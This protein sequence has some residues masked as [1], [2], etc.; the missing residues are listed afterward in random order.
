M[1]EA[2]LSEYGRRKLAGALNRVRPADRPV[3]HA[4]DR[5]VGKLSEVWNWCGK[6]FRAHD[7]VPA[8]PATGAMRILIVEDNPSLVAN[9]F[10][11]LERGG[12]TADAAP[13]GVTGLHLAQ[14]QEYDAIVLDWGLPRMDGREVLQRLRGEGRDVPVIMLTARGEQPDKIAGFRSGADD[15]LTKPFDLEELLLRL[16]ALVARSTGR[17]RLKVLQVGDLVLNL[18]TLEA[19]RG[20][21]SLH[22]YPAGRRILEVLMLASPG[23]VSR[24]RLEHALWGNDPPDGNLLRSHIYELRRSVDGP[25]AVK[26]IHTVAKA[27][28]RIAESGPDEKA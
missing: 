16:Q 19:T 24:E 25:F 9:L 14:T 27:G 12:H 13:D 8:Q 10:D 4:A 15:Y 6:A 3:P 26:L 2:E 21:T 7:G 28:Y 23:V 17:G 1:M 18:T 11:Y 5:P 22:L 20:G